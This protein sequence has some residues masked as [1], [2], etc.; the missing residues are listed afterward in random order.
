MF[1]INGLMWE[2]DLQARFDEVT[3]RST[4]LRH[5]FDDKLGAGAKKLLSFNKKLLLI[6]N[7]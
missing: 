2:K 5:T 7:A 4:S 6:D 3:K 1:G